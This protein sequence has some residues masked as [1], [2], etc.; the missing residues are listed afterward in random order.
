MEVGDVIDPAGGVRAP[1]RNLD[2]ARAVIK[3]SHPPAARDTFLNP[4]I[5]LWLA[6]GAVRQSRRPV[7]CVVAVFAIVCRMVW[8][9]FDVWIIWHQRPYILLQRAAVPA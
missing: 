4:A 6:E 9:L 2:L 8:G 3:D 5:S 1:A 7:D